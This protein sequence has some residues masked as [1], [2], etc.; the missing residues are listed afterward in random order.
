MAMNPV[1]R[2]EY[3]RHRRRRRR[4]IL[5]AVICL[6][7]V[8]GLG[9]VVYGGYRGVVALTDDTAERLDYENRLRTVVMYDPLPFDSL[10]KA[11]PIL[12]RESCIWGAI[13][14]AK[15][16][17]GNFDNYATDEQTGCLILPA[18]EVDAFASTLMGPFYTLTHEEFES[19]GMIYAYSPELQG[20]L[21]PV[22]SE[23]GRYTPK[24]TKLHKE[25]RKMR[26][27]VGYV[28]QFDPNDQF[29]LTAPSEPVKYMDY[30]FTRSDKQFYMT[31]L[32]ESQTKASASAVQN[33]PEVD[34]DVDFDPNQA[35]KENMD[36]ELLKDAVGEPG[37][38]QPQEPDVQDEQAQSASDADEES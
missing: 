19:D 12:L 29:S 13:Y 15:L 7:V 31:A 32:E 30:I 1:D 21:I 20:Y 35:L 17:Q 8:L 16:S 18:V 9:T 34:L 5:G 11:D 22:T 27:T 3:A 24:V 25:G 26:V 28:P 38:D 36:E 6:L 10:E 14:T 37:T 23:A 33:A 2:A 4:Q